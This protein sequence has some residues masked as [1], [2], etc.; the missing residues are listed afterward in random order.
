MTSESSGLSTRIRNGLIALG[1]IAISITLFFSLQADNSSLSLESQAEQA[2]PLE[3]AMNN[4]KPTLIEFY[5]NWCTSCQTMA[6][7]V[8]QLK[9]KYNESI[10]FVMLN[11][12]NEKWLPEML[13][14]QVDSIPNFT[15]L[16]AD[17]RQLGSVI[18]EHPQAVLEQNLQA[19]QQNE[20]LPYQR[21]QGQSSQVERNPSET[22]NP[23]VTPRSH[24]S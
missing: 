3:V 11:V 23:E 5:A 4:N 16:A 6:S 2:T 14:Y 15:F 12:D 21:N 20:S 7:E 13:Q 22:N 17:G 1:A 18:G 9:N 24:G 10:N 8:E 19:L